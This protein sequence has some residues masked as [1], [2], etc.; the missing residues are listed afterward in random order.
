MLKRGLKA[1]LAAIGFLV[2]LL[3]LDLAAAVIGALWRPGHVAVAA[4]DGVPIYL[5][6]S[7]IHTDIILP[8]RGVAV[9]WRS[10]LDDADAPASPPFD[11]YLA[12][13]WGSESFYKDVPTLADMTPAII[14]R[15]LFFDATVVHTAPVP[16]PLRIPPDR[17]RTLVISRE[18]LAALEAFVLSTFTLD[19]GRAEALAG[20]TYGYGDAFY[21]ADGRYTP[22]R[23]CNQWTSEALR[24]AGVSIGVWTPFSQSIVWTLGTDADAGG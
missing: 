23:T 12:F 8:V 7:D 24:L 1:V 9:D 13:G 18:G 6:W 10:V 19:A 17:R 5:V 11:G 4:G 21:H 3:V 16:D 20:E 15:A 14:A 22:I 2:A